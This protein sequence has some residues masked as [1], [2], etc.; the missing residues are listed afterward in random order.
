MTAS[1]TARR[2]MVIVDEDAAFGTSRSTPRSFAAPT[3][4]G[5]PV[6]PSFAGSK[7]SARPPGAHQPHPQPPIQSRH[8]TI[9][10]LGTLAVN[11]VASLILGVVTGLSGRLSADVV[12]LLGTGLGGALSRSVG[13]SFT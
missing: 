13:I 2:L 3:T 4:A 8:D 11:V 1:G 7:A 5:W 10:P 6:P 12:A 9:F